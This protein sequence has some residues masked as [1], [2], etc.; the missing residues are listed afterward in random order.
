MNEEG[1]INS[2]VAEIYGEEHAEHISRGIRTRI[3]SNKANII[4]RKAG[5]SQQDSF[6]ITYGDSLVSESM[7][8]LQAL[9]R[10]LTDYLQD[11]ITFV[12]L[13]PFFPFSSD[14]GFSVVDYRA[15]NPKVGAWE[16][17]ATLGSSYRL[18]FDAV[19]NHASVSGSYMQG[20]ASGE[21]RF[22]NFFIEVDENADLSQVVRPRSLSLVHEY[23][24]AKG[25][26][27]LW[28]TFSQDQVDLNY[29]NPDVLLEIIDVLLYYAQRGASM[30]RLDAIAYL[31]KQPGT[32]CIH[33]PQTH[34]IVKLFREVVRQAAP[35]TLIL[36]ETNV[37]HEENIS[38][39]GNGSD[40][41]HIVYNF[42][43]SPMILFSIATANA[44]KLTTWAT[45]LE[46]LSPQTTW[47]NFTASHDGIG[48]RPTEGILTDAERE[49]LFDR[50]KRHGG[51][52]S[53]KRNSDG[54]ES[55]YELNISYFDAI[56]PPQAEGPIQLQ[57][58]RFLLSQAIVLA[59]KGI[60]AIYIH[61]L[62][63]SRNDYAGLYKSG[64][65]RSINRARLSYE[66]VR[67]EL[68]DP[69][70]LRNRVFSRYRE[71][72]KIRQK[73]AA[74]HPTCAMQVLSGDPRLFAFRRST[75]SGSSI[76]AVFN[77][78]NQKVCIGKGL[79]ELPE[80]FQD[81][82]STSKTVTSSTQL[83]IHPYQFLWLA[84]ER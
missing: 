66:A 35:H 30:F 68:A 75:E 9:D 39:F 20:F 29:A 14:D 55:V 31:W 42:T 63:G 44:E 56:N 37:P 15:V 7:I 74:F 34:A 80:Q 38:Y 12:H 22:E 25:V 5:W 33:L 51:R 53:I 40:E 54:S 32:T 81:I 2:I 27:R 17:I 57:V 8:P 13:L 64:R 77:V 1:A 65:A 23:E 84:S 58:D 60:P 47:L 69:Q 45:G 16:D 76:T 41:A 28:T 4:P 67:A 10:L 24:T 21:A 48:V 6:L 50:V 61:S 71:L 72:L 59:F 11:A 19:I 82:A 52:L 79:L 49:L 73:H 83:T 62:L 78:S 3:D 43:L 46:P 36:T 70:S 18:V 26:K